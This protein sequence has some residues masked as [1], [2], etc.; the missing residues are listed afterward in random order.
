MPA[1]LPPGPRLPKTLQT[2]GWWT[3]TVP[4]LEGCRARYGNRFTLRLLQ[5]PPFVH[6]ADPADVREIFTAPPEV[7]HP[8]Q[9]AKILEPVVGA[10]SVILLDEG[11]HLS[12]RK[13]ML[14]AFHG[15]KMQRLSGLMQEVTEREVARWPRDRPL[16]LHP[17]LQAL[18]LEIILRGSSRSGTARPRCC[19]CSSTAAPGAS[20]SAAAPR[21]TR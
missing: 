1:G 5:S 17:R 14:P 16:T 9:G 13:L 8:G 15:E 21:R 12:Q 11:A 10:N 18:T 2:V 7:L 6:L 19:Q 3:R 20:S 4:F